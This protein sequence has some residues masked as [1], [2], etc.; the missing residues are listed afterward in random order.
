M[1]CPSS[2]ILLRILA[3]SASE[4]GLHL[5]WLHANHFTQGLKNCTTGT[6]LRTT[7][8]HSR[9]GREDMFMK[10]KVARIQFTDLVV[11]DNDTIVG[12]QQVCMLSP[13]SNVHVQFL[14]HTCPETLCVA[15]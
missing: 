7:K 3:C 12:I 1:V 6:G 14:C 2:S 8:M 13:H 10:G 4:N 5:T 9:D 15:T 11:R